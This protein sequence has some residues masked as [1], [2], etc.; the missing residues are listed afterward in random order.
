MLDSDEEDSDEDSEPEGKG[1]HK[2]DIDTLMT[3]LRHFPRLG[4]MILTF[5]NYDDLVATMG[6]YRPTTFDYLLGGCR[7]IIACMRSDAQ[8]FAEVPGDDEYVLLDPITLIPTGAPSINQVCSSVLLIR[9]IRSKLAH[10]QRRHYVLLVTWVR[11]VFLPSNPL[12][13]STLSG[14]IHSNAIRDY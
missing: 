11:I 3:Y 6:R 1:E 10:E 7:Y 2:I 5:D 12:F 4:T 14:I 13:S 8:T 9:M